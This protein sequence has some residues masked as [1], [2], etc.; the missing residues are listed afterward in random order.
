MTALQVNLSPP[1]G[2]SYWGNG[3]TIMGNTFNAVFPV[4]AKADGTFELVNIAPGGYKLYSTL[5]STFE[6]GWWL[7]SAMFEGR[8]LLD[9]PF[10][11]KSG[12]D[13]TGAVLTF[14]DQ[15][16]E[17][18]GTLQNAGGLP[19]TDYFVIA[20]PADRSLWRA[21]S[22]RVV[23]ARPGTDGAFTVRD[24]PPGNY[25]LAAVTDVEPADLDDA[26]FLEQLAPASVR[27]TLRDGDKKTQNLK[28]S[29]GLSPERGS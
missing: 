24:L 2:T 25:L 23:S 10:A 7:K 9:S 8:D 29:G 28:I 6:K 21:G 1:E 4:Y 16:T 12:E 27:V 13:M 11:V 17:L 20:F 14:S 19:T 18:S 15:H 3:G 22:R 26:S 5:P